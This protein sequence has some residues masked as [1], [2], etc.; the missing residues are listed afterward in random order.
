MK[1]SQ[2]FCGLTVSFIA[3]ISAQEDAAGAILLVGKSG[4]LRLRPLTHA[5]KTALLALAAGE[6]TEQELGQ[7]VLASEGISAFSQFHYHYRQ[8]V[9]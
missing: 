1:R 6:S 9:H 3:G 7:N 8:C 5:Q 4:T 2:T